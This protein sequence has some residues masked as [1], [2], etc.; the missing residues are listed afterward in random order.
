MIKAD[1]DK[2]MSSINS[3]NKRTEKKLELYEQKCAKVE[4]DLQ[5][6]ERELGDLEF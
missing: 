4:D 1:I 3:R 5:K 6:K 2:Q